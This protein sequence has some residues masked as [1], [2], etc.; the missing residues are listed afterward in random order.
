MFLHHLDDIE[1]MTVLR[2]M[3]RLTTHGMIWN[4][5]VRGPV[6]KLVVRLLVLGRPAM[7][8]HDAVVSVAAGFTKREALY[9]AARVG[10]SN[11]E[12]RRHMFGR[13]AL[14][15]TKRR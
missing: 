9:L 1:V 4:D 10:L 8:R 6:E 5:L 3:D 14:T 7:V 15:S 11:V 2:I 12:Y 13:F